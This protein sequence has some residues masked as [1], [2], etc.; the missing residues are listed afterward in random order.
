[1]TNT[2]ENL[3]PA[4]RAWVRD[5][6]RA[7]SAAA[8]REAYW[9]ACAANSVFAHEAGVTPEMRKLLFGIGMLLGQLGD[10]LEEEG[11]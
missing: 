6:T 8:R 3:S 7:P 5:R 10:L 4:A 9:M 1:M 2:D 11:S